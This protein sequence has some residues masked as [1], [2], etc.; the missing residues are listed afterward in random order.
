MEGLREYG[1]R[2]EF[3]S[4]IKKRARVRI[5]ANKVTHM[6]DGGGW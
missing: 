1:R 6:L 3:L 4:T 5:E 2:E